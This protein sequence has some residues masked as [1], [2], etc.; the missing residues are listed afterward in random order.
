M[1]MPSLRSLGL[2]ALGLFVCVVPTARAQKQGF[3]VNRYEPTPAG[4]WSFWTDHPWYSSTRYFAGGL[5]LDYAH[6][7]LFNYVDSRD[8]GFRRQFPIIE[9]Q[10]TGHLDLAGSFLDRVT[11]SASLPV[12]FVERGTAGGGVTPA[13][14]VVVGDPRFGVMVRIWGQPDKTPFSISVG[15]HIWVPLRKYTDSIPAQESDQEV[16]GLPK[17]VLAGLW[18]RFRWSFTFGAL[19]R[20]EAIL[21]VAQDV[22][23]SFTGSSLQ[24]GVLAQYFDMKRHFAVGPEIQLDTIVAGGNAFKAD[25]TALE[26]L[27][28]LHYSVEHLIQL[29]LA[30]GFGV[31]REPGTP[32]GRFLLRVA[33]APV[34]TSD[35][36]RDGVADEDDRCPDVPRGQHPDPDRRGCP[37]GDRDHD[38]YTD[39]KDRCPDEP[40]GDHPDPKQPGCPL[41]DTDKDGVFD[42]TDQCVS[43]PAGPHPDPNRPG[44]PIRDRDEDGVA[45]DVDICPTVPKGPYPDPKRRGCPSPDTDGDGYV[46][47]RD[48]CPKTPAGLRPDPDLPGC[49]LIDTDGDTVPDKVDACPTVKG[50]PNPDPKKNG[51]PG[52]A[53]LKDG[54]IEIA[55]EVFFKTA[56][57]KILKKSDEVLLAV[58]N[59][60]KAT[61]EIKK[62]EIAAFT[63]DRGSDSFNLDLSQRRAES[64][65][66]WMVA[67]GVED[68]RVAV[69]GYGKLQLVAGESKN[70]QRTKNRRVEFRILDPPQ[71][72]LAPPPAGLP[73]LV[74]APPT[75]AYD[76]SAPAPV[77]VGPVQDPLDQRYDRP[78]ENKKP[79]QKPG[80]TPDPLQER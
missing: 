27:L 29:G 33:Y 53:S 28:G 9:H 24:F 40:S 64:V 68:G 43:E 3:Q 41:R 19:I 59:V 52:L 74:S 63:D 50:S 10:F 21:G 36:D 25:F 51:C 48:R 47:G 4:E 16:R 2:I 14:G 46:D 76:P 13:D 45:D 42:I 34:R 22:S 38:N 61:P 54:R 32:D 65:K 60:L 11:L 56:Q 73:D 6:A 15:G 5:T 55:G 12:V 69:K 18:K 26:F 35:R 79:G 44:C 23:G 70:K 49:P 39:H 78:E 30:G 7:P 57:A 77:P 58:A 80:S 71:G 62:M 37:D 20:S 31:L 67:H 8:A 1:S 75:E 72:K 66:V 17:I